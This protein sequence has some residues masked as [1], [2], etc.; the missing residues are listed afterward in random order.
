MNRSTTRVKPFHKTSGIFA[1]AILIWSLFRSY[2][3]SELFVI[4]L[5][6]TLTALI[7]NLWAFISSSAILTP[8]LIFIALVLFRQPINEWLGK[9][10]KLKAFG[11]EYESDIRASLL[12]E[13]KTAASEGLML[14]A[15]GTAGANE[16]LSGYINSMPVHLA[17]LL[18]T[19]NNRRVTIDEAMNLVYSI[20]LSPTMSSNDENSQAFM[21]LAV[22]RVLID[23]LLPSVGSYELLNSPEFIKITLH[24]D[25]FELLQKKTIPQASSKKDG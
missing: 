15:Q 4:S 2:L 22:L 16:F 11:M 10:T 1:L 25:A 17:Q 5:D 6:Q 8:I 7:T 19:L 21:S 20:Y 12:E 18:L 23:G 9:V 14:S 13:K 3:D 24:P